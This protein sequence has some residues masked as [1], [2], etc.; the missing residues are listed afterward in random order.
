MITQ[1]N[2]IAELKD[3]ANN[4]IMRLVGTSAG[5]PIDGVTGK[6]MAG[7]GSTFTS[8]GVTGPASV[9]IN[10]GTKASPKWRTATSAYGPIQESGVISSA[11]LT[12]TNPG[13]FGHAAGYPLIA[14]QGVSGILPNILFPLI[15]FIKYR[16]ATAS[17]TGGVAGV[18]TLNWTTA[19]PGTPVTNSVTSAN[20]LLQTSSTIIML[21]PLTTPLVTANSS[22][23]SSPGVG[24]NLVTSVAF[25]NPGTAAGV[26]F[27]HI[28][29]NTT[30]SV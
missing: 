28:I 3:L 16:W 4:D 30:F 17:Y 5:L 2:I 25:T 7:P 1:P 12:G 6:G 23:S 13:Q 19:S 22:L 29:Y 14:G 26:V 11:D 20:F 27:W 10:I 15:V 18:T 9:Y 21:T 24:L 8:P